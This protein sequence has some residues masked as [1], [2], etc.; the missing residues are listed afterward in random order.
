MSMDTGA[1]CHSGG[2]YVFA[3]CNGVSALCRTPG[4]LNARGRGQLFMYFEGV[5]QMLKCPAGTSPTYPMSQQC[6]SALCR[7]PGFLTVFLNA[8]GLGSVDKG[9]QAQ[10]RHARQMRHRVKT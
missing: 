9:G 10:H 6:V 7:T 1:A 2:S 5:F 4:F 3:N 8:P